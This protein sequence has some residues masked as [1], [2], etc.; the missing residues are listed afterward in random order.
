MKQ[1]TDQDA[2]FEQYRKERKLR[3]AQNAAAKGEVREGAS[4]ARLIDAADA[5]E[6][7]DQQLTREVHEFFSDATRTAASIVQKF[8]ER[9]TVEHVSKVADEMQEF[10]QQAIHRAQNFIEKIR[11]QGPTREAERHVVAQMQ[12]L[13]GPL[14]DHFRSIGTAAVADKHIGQDPFLVPAADEERTDIEDHIVAEVA[15][16]G[17]KSADRPGPQ[18]K[19]GAAPVHPLLG[20]IGEEPDR[21]KKAL[22][23]LVDGNLMSREE[24]QRIWSERKKR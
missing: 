19:R 14:L 11:A 23:L 2:G 12:N 9:K 4:V 1:R 3:R 7:H 21:L 8:H 10:L 24:A 22:R 20:G 17:D 18:A 5:K 16:V 13:V 6:A 15:E